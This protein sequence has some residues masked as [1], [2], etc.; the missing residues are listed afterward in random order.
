MALVVWLMASAGVTSVA[1]DIKSN[2][3][4]LTVGMSHDL[5]E[6]VQAAIADLASFGHANDDGLPEVR[7]RCSVYL[8]GLAHAIEPLLMNRP[9]CCC[10]QDLLNPVH[11]ERRDQPAESGRS[12]A[13]PPTQR[14]LQLEGRLR[15]L[16]VKMS[17][18]RS[19]MRKLYHANVGVCSLWPLFLHAPH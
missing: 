16:E 3:D 17:M 6:K 14:E 18:S 9:Q 7:V 19:I 8:H 12:R 10:G 2:I 15:Q 4:G 5:R 13:R 1:S 11:A